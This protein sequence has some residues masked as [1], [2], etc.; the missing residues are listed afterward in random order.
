MSSEQMKEI[1][2]QLEKL[3]EGVIGRPVF[4]SY[5]VGRGGVCA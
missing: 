3:Q 5:R 1:V 4:A 2:A